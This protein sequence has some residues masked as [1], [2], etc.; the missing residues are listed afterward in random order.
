MGGTV[1]RPRDGLLCAAGALEKPMFDWIEDDMIEP[2]P[3]E[4]AF[5]TA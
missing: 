4:S 1:D 3:M 5:P 2:D